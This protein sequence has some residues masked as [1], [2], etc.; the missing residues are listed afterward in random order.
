M[1]VN[2]LNFR[3]KTNSSGPRGLGL[4]QT[5]TEVGKMRRKRL[6]FDNSMK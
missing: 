2:D 4:S 3:V 5:G 1:F 6:K